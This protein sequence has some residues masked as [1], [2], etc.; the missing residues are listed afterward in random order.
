M[1]VVLR[2]IEMLQGRTLK[3]KHL[4]SLMENFHG[5]GGVGILWR[6]A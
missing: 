3:V 6:G 4:L 1:N 2:E 5:R